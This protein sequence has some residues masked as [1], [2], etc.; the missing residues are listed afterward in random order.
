MMAAL[1]FTAVSCSKDDEGD[2][3]D[4][5][6]TSL[7]VIV[8]AD[9]FVSGD[10]SLSVPA[11]LKAGDKMGIFAVENGIILNDIV[12]V[13]FTAADDG[14]GG[15][16]WKSEEEV[17]FPSGSAYY[18]YMPYQ[19]TLTTAPD[20]SAGDAAGG[21]QLFLKLNAQGKEVDAVPGLFAHG[22]VAQNAGLA[23]ADHR[24]A[25]GQAAQLAGLD[26]EGAPR[27]G[28]LKLAVVGEGLFA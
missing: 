9:S 27:K 2:G 20:P 18:A 5:P 23:V 11:E 19:E 21:V 25:V 13:C 26:H 12:N 17:T 28:G 22:D 14:N 4:V 8:T 1:L 6:S 7:D 3:I 15:L 10:G 24:A 16:V